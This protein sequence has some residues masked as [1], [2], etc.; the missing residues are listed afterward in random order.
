MLQTKINYLHI[1]NLS[2]VRGTPER[3]H[4][5]DHRDMLAEDVQAS[6]YSSCSARIW[7]PYG[8]VLSPNLQRALFVNQE[9]AARVERQTN[10]TTVNGS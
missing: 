2:Q 7:V 6:S 9:Q 1:Q 10:H 8:V 5:R 4:E 3:R